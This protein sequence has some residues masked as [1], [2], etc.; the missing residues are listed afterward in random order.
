MIGIRHYPHYYNILLIIDSMEFMARSVY[1]EVCLKCFKS[2]LLL[3][4]YHRN[5]HVKRKCELC[6]KDISAANF[7]RH[8]KEHHLV[9]DSH[10]NGDVKCEKCN[11][12]FTRKQKLT[13]HE[14]S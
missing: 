11:S 4:K 13:E 12:S 7:N 14:K 3:K 6:S 9:L 5:I 1:C 10:I 2:D 8:K